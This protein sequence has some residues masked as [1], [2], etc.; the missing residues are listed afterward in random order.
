MAYGHENRFGLR[1]LTI[2]QAKNREFSNVILLWPYEVVP[3]KRNKKTI[4]QRYIA[5][6]GFLYPNCNGQTC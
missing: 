4:I 1:A 6:K 2:H 3:I 5:S